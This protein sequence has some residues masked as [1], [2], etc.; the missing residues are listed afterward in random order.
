MTAAYAR[1][2]CALDATIPVIDTATGVV[3]PPAFAAYLVQA[4]SIVADTA[5]TPYVAT[6]HVCNRVRFS[7]V[8]KAPDAGSVLYASLSLAPGAVHG[9]AAFD[10]R[11]AAVTG[12]TATYH[13]VSTATGGMA[14][15]NVARVP[16][17]IG[18]YGSTV[19]LFLVAGEAIHESANNI[20]DAPLSPTNRLLE[21][22][23]SRHHR[24]EDVKLLVASGWSIRVVQ[25]AS[26]LESL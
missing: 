3:T 19:G 22:P 5:T 16:W 6:G 14:G 17:N 11:E 1:N 20:N 21:L 24:V 15:A 10:D 9:K 13:E 26:N 12:N 2:W 25:L 4:A 7:G 23:Q 8:P 18:P